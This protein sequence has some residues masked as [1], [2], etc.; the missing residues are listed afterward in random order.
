MK[1]KGGWNVIERKKNRRK[2]VKKRKKRG[3]NEKNGKRNVNIQKELKGDEKNGK[4][5]K[6]N[7]G[8]KEKMKEKLINNEI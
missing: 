3:R 8:D 7:I 5:M 6:R 1:W 4:Q 2:N